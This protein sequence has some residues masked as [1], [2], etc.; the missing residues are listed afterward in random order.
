[1]LRKIIH[2]LL[3]VFLMV[4]TVGVTLSLHYC[5]GKLSSAS[6]N[7]QAESCCDMG[8]CCHNESIHFEL[9]ENYVSPAHVENV[10]LVELDILFPI[11]FVLNLQL[12]PEVEKTF[13][14]FIDISPPLATQTR[15]CLLQTYL[16]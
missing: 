7:G 12:L 9:K 10:K 13:E 14:V 16:C 6:I 4:S 8:N 1:M 3:A 5:G 2:I 15:L 11:L